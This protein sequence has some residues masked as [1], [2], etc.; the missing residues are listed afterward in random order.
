MPSITFKVQFSSHCSQAAMTFP[1]FCHSCTAILTSLMLPSLRNAASSSQTNNKMLLAP[2]APWKPANQPPNHREGPV[3]GFTL[4]SSVS[5]GS[6]FAASVALPAAVDIALIFL[7]EQNGNLSTIFIILIEMTSCPP[8]QH[9]Y[10]TRSVMSQVTEEH[11]D[12][13]TNS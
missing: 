11:F 3:L 6:A 5:G 7:R 12:L 8:L 4:L 10:V 9:I 2:S 13:N 1:I